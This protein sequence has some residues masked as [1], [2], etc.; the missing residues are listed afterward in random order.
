MAK[1]IAVYILLALVIAGAILGFSY[2]SASHPK[3]S[4]SPPEALNLAALGNANGGGKNLIQSGSWYRK[5]ADQGDMEAQAFLGKSSLICDKDPSDNPS[6]EEYCLFAA[7]AGDP[8]AQYYVGTF[9]DR[10]N[11]TQDY[12]KAIEWYRRAA[13]QGYLKAQMMLGRLYGKGLGVPP[14]KIE[15]YAWLSVVSKQIPNDKQE[16]FFID[17]A[18]D[19]MKVYLASFDKASKQE[20][21]QREEHYRQQFSRNRLKEGK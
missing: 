19:V 4:V 7:G 16:E 11:L 14:D 9:Y 12:T 5:V 13:E 2:Y 10:G 6:W 15:A 3:R 18:E 20:A 1:R 17:G 21:R 8:N